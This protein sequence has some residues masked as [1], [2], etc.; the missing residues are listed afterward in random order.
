MWFTGLIWENII[1]FVI[2]DS[3]SGAHKRE[4]LNT[5]KNSFHKQVQYDVTVN[6][7]KRYYCYY[8][9]GIGHCAVIEYSNK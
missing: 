1:Q 5:L 2:Y 8:H 6:G 4:V 7:I 9:Y 3:K